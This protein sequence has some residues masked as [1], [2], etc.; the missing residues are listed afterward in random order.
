VGVVLVHQSVLKGH[1]VILVLPLTVV[2]V[3]MV[4][5]E[6]RLKLALSSL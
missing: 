2:V 5:E 3:V 1:H 6:G 4:G